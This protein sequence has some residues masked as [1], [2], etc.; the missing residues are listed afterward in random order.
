MGL[1]EGGRV[2]KGGGRVGG[3]QPQLIGEGFLKEGRKEGLLKIHC[4]GL[5]AFPPSSPCVCNGEV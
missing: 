1:G 5:S 3:R 4:C 2:K